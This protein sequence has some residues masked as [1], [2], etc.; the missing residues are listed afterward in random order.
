MEVKTHNFSASRII[1]PH[2]RQDFLLQQKEALQAER[3]RKPQLDRQGLE[4]FQ[5]L[6]LESLHQGLAVQIVAVTK[7]GRTVTTGIVKGIDRKKGRV[8]VQT[9]EEE[10]TLNACDIIDILG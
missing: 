7:S 6:L 3:I 8:N 10:R 4:E 5:R 1:L 2:H 9:L